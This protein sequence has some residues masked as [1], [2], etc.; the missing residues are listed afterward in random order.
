[1]WGIDRGTRAVDRVYIE[2]FLERHQADI[3]GCVLEVAASEYTRRFGQG[4]VGRCD[5][6]DINSGNSNATIIADLASG[7]P[8]HQDRFDCV[9]LTQTL[10]LIYDIRAALAN[11]FG[12]LK[13]GGVLL[14]TLPSVSR[15]DYEYG[16]PH[17][18]DFWRFT[19]ASARALFREVF[20]PECVEVTTHGNLRACA[21]FLLGLAAEEVDPAVLEETD[22]WL[23]LVCCIRA[24]KPAVDQKSGAR[25]LCAGVIESNL[26]RTRGAILL[27]H[28]VGLRSAD[29]YDLN[30]DVNDFR[31]HMRHLR[32]RWSPMA[33]NDLID[34]VKNGEAPPGAVAITLD[35]GYV[36]NLTTVSPI[37]AEFDL[38][39]AFFVN[40]ENLH[41][42]HE[43]WWDILHR[44]MTAAG[45]L[46]AVLDLYGDGRW[47]RTVVTEADRAVAHRALIETLY[48]MSGQQRNEVIGRLR[49]W[50]G[51]ELSARPTHR[52]MTGDEIVRLAAQ[53]RHAIGAHSVHHLSLPLHP[54]LQVEEVVESKR[55]LERLL[56]R[57]VTTFAYPYGDVDR[58]TI[59][60][61]QHAGFSTAVTVECRLVRPGA[62]RLLIPRVEIKHCNEQEFAQRLEG[63]F[64][65]IPYSD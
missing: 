64:G 56:G 44:I 63:L 47:V 58:R 6:L 54:A 34:A 26:V 4:R 9:I 14:C 62:E 33:L 39:A 16:G 35:D 24:M 43:G 28:R 61:V 57:P 60:R 55:E 23:P 15:V 12:M 2:A 29:T 41:E 25:A 31:D 50:S 52:L 48:P 30:I 13:P 51:L 10:H 11:V 18:G 36:D 19:E 37:L 38:P 17:D 42:P 20:P 46:P 65:S 59:E 21:A 53:P 1:V 40:T 27:Y 8:L 7:S 49:E 3:Q 45:P 32:N 22:P 5:V